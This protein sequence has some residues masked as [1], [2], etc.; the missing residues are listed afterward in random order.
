MRDLWAERHVSRRSRYPQHIANGAFNPFW[1]PNAMTLLVI[2]VHE[3]MG[4]CLRI[5]KARSPRPRGGSERD[6]ELQNLFSD[7]AER[8]K[9]GR[10]QCRGQPISN[11]QRLSTSPGGSREGGVVI[12]PRRIS[13]TK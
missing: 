9:R 13:R 10:D 12:C 1:E 4:W 5:Y 8:R 6:D 11:S 2:C 3:C 7:E